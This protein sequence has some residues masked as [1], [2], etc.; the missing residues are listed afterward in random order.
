MNR[1]L[2]MESIII[3]IVASPGHMLKHEG[4]IWIN[5]NE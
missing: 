4:I 3:E 1:S 2:G 5:N